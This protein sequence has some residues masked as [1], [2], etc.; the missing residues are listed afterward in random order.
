MAD[1]ASKS[2]EYMEKLVFETES[3][4]A[5]DLRMALDTCGVELANLAQAPKEE[6][7]PNLNQVPQNPD[8]FIFD[9]NPGQEEWKEPPA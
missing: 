1:G 4:E 8:Q 6:A 9:L 3:N 7:V 2:L 5:T